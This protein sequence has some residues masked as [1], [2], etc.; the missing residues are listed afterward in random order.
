MEFL[1]CSGA[2]L[3]IIFGFTFYS[4][5]FSLDVRNARL[6]RVMLIA[7]GALGALL[8]VL[9]AVLFF[10]L[11]SKSDAAATEK[12]IIEDVF[13]LFLS[14]DIIMVAVGM[15]ITLVSSLVKSFLRPLIPVVLPLWGIIT[16]FW[17]AVCYAWSEFESFSA[18]LYVILFGV[19]AAFLLA[20][21]V[22][23]QMH[24]R[25]KV[26]SDSEKRGEIIAAIK[27]K[28]AKRESRRAERKRLREQKKR[29]MHPKKK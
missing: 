24:E 16:L 22:L 27:R 3:L 21:S 23:P 20:F 18:S 13:V 29:L 5:S 14:V 28:R 8:A 12:G 4:Y 15:V 19:G 9:G 2:L 11:L 6:S 1:I 10:I 26:L 25:I 7:T 17:T